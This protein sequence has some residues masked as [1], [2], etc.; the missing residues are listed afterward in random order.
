MNHSLKLLRKLLYFEGLLFISGKFCSINDSLE[1]IT[2]NFTNVS[3]PGATES[4]FFLY[5]TTFCNKKV[6][7]QQV[8]DV[9]DAKLSCPIQPITVIS[10]IYE[11]CTVRFL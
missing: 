3:P 6:K 4:I 9:C 8:F 2:L 10:S 1:H 5:T 7:L 11:A